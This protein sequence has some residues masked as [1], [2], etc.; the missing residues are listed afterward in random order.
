MNVAWYLWDF[1]NRLGENCCPLIIGYVA[2]HELIWVLIPAGSSVFPF[3]H[4]PMSSAV[5]PTAHIEHNGI[6]DIF[7]EYFVP[8]K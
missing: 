8:V 6:Q 7:S 1:L 5:L 4:S 2:F 3:K